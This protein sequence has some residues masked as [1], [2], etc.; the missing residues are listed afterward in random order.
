MHNEEYSIECEFMDTYYYYLDYGVNLGTD[1]SG[2]ILSVSY[3]D[4][5]WGPRLN[6]NYLSQTS[7][8]C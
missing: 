1:E 7:F 3:Y 6:V 8:Y 2:C 5:G 4:K